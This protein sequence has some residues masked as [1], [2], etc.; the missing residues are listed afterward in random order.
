MMVTVH[1]FHSW[2]HSNLSFAIRSTGFC[3]RF[4]QI[5]ALFN[6]CFHF[7]CSRCFRARFDKLHTIK[8]THTLHNHKSWPQWKTIALKTCCEP[9][10]TPYSWHRFA[11]T[12]HG[13]LRCGH[14][15]STHANA[16]SGQRNNENIKWQ[17]ITIMQRTNWDTHIR[18][19]ENTSINLLK[20]IMIMNYLDIAAP[21]SGFHFYFACVPCERERDSDEAVAAAVSVLPMTLWTRDIFPFDLTAIGL[22]H[23]YNNNN[24]RT[25]ANEWMN[26]W[27][28]K[29]KGSATHENG[30]IKQKN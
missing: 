19:S 11:D 18:G 30:K 9:S 20:I 10:C 24:M 14:R 28:R 22:H 1:V 6:I 15:F 25:R 21:E 13:P 16:Q 29:K 3:N 23:T 2:A 5:V 4:S 8:G 12:T 26:E 17:K 7:T 27:R